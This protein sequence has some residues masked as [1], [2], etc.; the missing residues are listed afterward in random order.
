MTEVKRETGYSP[1]KMSS[2]SSRFA[3]FF[4]L[5][6]F[7]EGALVLLLASGLFEGAPADEVLD[8]CNGRVAPDVAADSEV[9]VMLGV[10]WADGVVAVDIGL[11][12]IWDMNSQPVCR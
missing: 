12:F 6:G 11:L 2:M 8:V 3:N 5:L 1:A 4:C 10:A 7:E 9:G